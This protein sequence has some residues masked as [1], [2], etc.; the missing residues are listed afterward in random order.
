[1]KQNFLRN[2]RKIK[3]INSFARDYIIDGANGKRES[4]DIENLNF[5]VK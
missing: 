3:G 5:T 4:G 2:K 1:M